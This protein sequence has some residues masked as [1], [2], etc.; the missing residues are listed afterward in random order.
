MKKYIITILL[1]LLSVLPVFAD[2]TI[3][4]YFESHPMELSNKPVQKNGTTLVPLRAIFDALGFNVVWDEKTKTVI[5]S[6]NDTTIKLTIGSKVAYVNGEAQAISVAPQLIKGTTYVPLRFVSEAAG[7]SVGW[8]SE[9]R[10]ITIGENDQ[11]LIDVYEMASVYDASNKR[12]KLRYQDMY[13]VKGQGEYSGYTK[14]MGHPYKGYDLYYKSSSNG[15]T[16][17]SHVIIL[18]TNINFN[19][20]VKWTYNGTTYRSTK[21]EVF[22]YFSDLAQI[23]GYDINLSEDK[24]RKL[25]G[26]VYDEWIS[27]GGVN[28]DASRFVEGYIEYIDG[29]AF[30]L[31]Y[32]RYEKDKASEELSKRLEK[33][34]LAQKEAAKK[35]ALKKELAQKELEK[36]AEARKALQLEAEQKEKDYE[37][38]IKAIYKQFNDEW[39]TSENLKDNYG[40]SAIW[41]GETIL[42]TKNNNKIYTIYGSPRS[43]FAQGVVYN[44]NGIQYA[45]LRVV[46][47]DFP[48]AKDGSGKL[49]ITVNELSFK[50]ADLR[51]AGIIN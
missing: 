8:N 49:K 19:Q 33:E 41:M 3:P 25:F 51:N 29:S 37:A 50:T 20:V 5:A 17:T 48:E 6:S 27:Y 22:N 26:N 39:T 42:F 31:Y 44:G 16:S 35:E 13:T 36:E 32:S 23:P 7:Y 18:P 4:V 12:G 30:D 46:E 24:L 40:I 10:Y 1:C 38:K 45:Y 28:S 2:A 21:G 15:S 11:A 14:L 9:N 34:E 47:Y 43:S